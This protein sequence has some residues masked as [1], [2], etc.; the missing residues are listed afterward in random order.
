VAVLHCCQDTRFKILMRL[1]P[2]LS[3]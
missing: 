2:S 3:T 1:T